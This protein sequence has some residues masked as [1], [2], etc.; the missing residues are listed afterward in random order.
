MADAAEVVFLAHEPC[1]NC[2]SSDNLARYSDGHA[3]CFG[4]KHY[5]PPTGDPGAGASRFNKEPRRM[6][7]L[8]EGDYKDLPARG[9]TIETL[10][11]FGYKLGSHRNEG[12]HLAPYRDRDGE[13]VAQKI[14]TKAKD[15]Y[16]LGEPKRVFQLFGQHLWGTGGRRV[17]VTEGE[18]DCMTVSQVQDHKWPVVSV[19]GGA[20]DTQSITRSLAWLESFDEVV[21]MFDA[22]EPGREGARKCA[23]L[24]SPG[25]A[26]IA[27]LPDGTDPNDLLTKGNRSA[28]VTA[29]FEA[30]TYRPDGLRTLGELIS[31][32]CKPAQWGYSLPFKTLYELSYGPQPG[33]LWIGGAGVGIG[34]TDVVTEMIVEDI[35]AGRPCIAFLLEQQPE[36]T[37]K[38]VAAKLAG[39]PFF[40]PTCEYTEDELRAVLEPYK[41]LLHIYDH[42]GSTEWEEIERYIR[43]AK[44]AYGIQQ[45]YVDNLTVLAADAAD[46]RRYLDGLLKSM[47]SLATDLGI[48]LHA[49]SHLTTPEGTP[50]EEGGRVEAKQFAGSRAIMRYADYMWGLERDTQHEDP[51][52]RSIST[53]RVLKDRI[54]GQS[55]GRTFHLRYDPQTT[56]MAECAAPVHAE[57]GL[58]AQSDYSF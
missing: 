8:I 11:K 43:W 54:S 49:L 55:N 22:D 18:I 5:E 40:L 10:R 19:S 58:A 2:G 9:L 23:A 52:M 56:R 32:A 36:E 42:R 24:L 25:K 12:V 51:D 7:G 17:V 27:S 57:G 29:I 6:S 46:E 34:K 50:H 28:I 1:P 37:P 26:K 33:Q 38:R 41:D 31:A 53:F 45:A 48:C 35:K 16:W 44:H 4:C 21:F 13:V 3:Y 47:K 39:K 20:G 15:F 30:Q 14:R